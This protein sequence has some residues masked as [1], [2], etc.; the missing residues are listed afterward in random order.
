MKRYILR[1]LLLAVPGAND[2]TE[3]RAFLYGHAAALPGIE[4]A[5]GRFAGQFVPRARRSLSWRVQVDREGI[6]DLLLSSYRGARRRECERL[7]RAVPRSVTL[8][9]EVALLDW[10]I[11]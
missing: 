7:A 9:R 11:T 4:A 10:A 5:L 2:L 6:A 3:L 1:R 8:A